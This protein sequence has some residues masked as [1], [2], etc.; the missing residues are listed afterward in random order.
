MQ[1]CIKT[2]DRLPLVAH[3]DQEVKHLATPPPLSFILGPVPS[4]WVKPRGHWGR[5]GGVE[6]EGVERAFS[7]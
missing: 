5:G 3:S 7:Y 1:L 6:K 4:H 2:Q